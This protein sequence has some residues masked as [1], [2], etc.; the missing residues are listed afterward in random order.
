VGLP[1]IRNQQRSPHEGLVEQTDLSEDFRQIDEVMSFIDPLDADHPIR[2]SVAYLLSSFIENA[3]RIDELYS[4]AVKEADL[5]AVGILKAATRSPL[6][7]LWAAVTKKGS[8][9]YQENQSERSKFFMNYIGIVTLRKVNQDMDRSRTYEEVTEGAMTCLFVLKTAFEEAFEAPEGLI[10][11]ED[12]ESM[13]FYLPAVIENAFE[14][15]N[16]VDY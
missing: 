14:Y 4:V 9:Y 8:S 1:R 10:K 12:Y 3:Q 7:L 16:R 6:K 11:P 5:A 13:Q 2:D 15:D